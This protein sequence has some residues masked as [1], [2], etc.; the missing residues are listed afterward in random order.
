MWCP[1]TTVPASVVVRSFLGMLRLAFLPPDQ[2]L[3]KMV[4]LPVGKHPVTE[5]SK[6]VG[7]HVPAVFC[8]TRFQ[9][10][11]HLNE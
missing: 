4:P 6:T 8:L 2:S 1:V 5:K 7:T 9:S 3:V 10:R 11:Q